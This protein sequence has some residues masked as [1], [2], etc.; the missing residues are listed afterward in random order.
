MKFEFKNGDIL[1][2]RGGQGGNVFGHLVRLITGSEY[3][4][5]GVIIQDNLGIFNVVE[6]D[7]STGHVTPVAFF[8]EVRRLL[9]ENLAVSRYP[10][11]RML[12]SNFSTICAKLRTRYG[13]LSLMDALINH[14]LGRLFSWFGK[15]YTRRPFLSTFTSTFTCAGFITKI[16]LGLVTQDFPDYRVAEPDDFVRFG[17]KVVAEGVEIWGKSVNN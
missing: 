17:F 4:H 8:C 16:L 12:P 5:C 1:L 10:D 15:E 11:L 9:P 7:S 13:F 6:Q 3:T 2:V 14:P